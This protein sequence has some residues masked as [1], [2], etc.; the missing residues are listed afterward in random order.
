MESVFCYGIT[1]C[2]LLNTMKGLGAGEEGEGG[3]GGW[4]SRGCTP[5][6][7]WKAQYVQGLP[8]KI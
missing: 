3:G 7:F 4:V 2:P 5:K 1:I 6:I 8:F